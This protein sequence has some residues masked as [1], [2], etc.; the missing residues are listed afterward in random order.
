MSRGTTLR[1]VRVDDNLWWR[2]RAVAD[3]RGDTL[4]GIIRAA[5]LRY[6]RRHEGAGS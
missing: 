3:A 4:S 2:A 6:V 1:S 5:L